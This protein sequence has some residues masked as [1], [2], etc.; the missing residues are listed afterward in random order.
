MVVGKFEPPQ[1]SNE[2]TDGNAKFKHSLET[3]KEVPLFSY[4]FFP[5]I[6]DLPP[7]VRLDASDSYCVILPPMFEGLSP[8]QSHVHPYSALYLAGRNLK[9]ILPQSDVLRAHNI[10]QTDI[11]MILAIWK[12]WSEVQLESDD[13]SESVS[14]KSDSNIDTSAPSYMSITSA[15]ACN[16][17]L[18]LP[19]SDD[20]KAPVSKRMRMQMQQAG[21]RI[22]ETQ[23]AV[24]NR[25]KINNQLLSP[26]G[27]FKV[28]CLHI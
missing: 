19:L 7:F 1:Q 17:H 3:P 13:T 25:D 10:D 23:T 8:L 18:A 12:V 20:F 22:A 14:T 6:Q 5:L 24:L 28:D 26:Q 15:S 11:D 2:I 4:R 16:D 9:S 27:E 21:V